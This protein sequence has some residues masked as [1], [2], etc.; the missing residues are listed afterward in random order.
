MLSFL[1]QAVFMFQPAQPRELTARA[2][3]SCKKSPLSNNLLHLFLNGGLNR[4][5]VK[6]RNCFTY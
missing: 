1:T 4:V 3:S 6:V 5:G 2:A